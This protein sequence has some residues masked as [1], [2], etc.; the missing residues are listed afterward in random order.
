MADS[1]NDEEYDTVDEV[2]AVAPSDVVAVREPD[3]LL[4]LDTV[5]VVDGLVPPVSDEVAL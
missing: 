4:E 1:D 2:D 3:V 5:D